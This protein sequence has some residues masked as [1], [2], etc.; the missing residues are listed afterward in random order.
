MDP[1]EALVQE[2]VSCTS[3]DDEWAAWVR[4]KAEADR[5]RAAN[6]QQKRELERVESGMYLK[7]RDELSAE[8]ERLR[9]IE[10]SF[11]AL[12]DKWLNTIDENE[13]LRAATRAYVVAVTRAP[14]NRDEAEVEA[15]SAGLVQALKATT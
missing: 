6:E 3:N 5:L 10:A 12:R 15:A 14:N 1:D 9:D 13:R 7:M 11:D 4:Y 2:V 8:V